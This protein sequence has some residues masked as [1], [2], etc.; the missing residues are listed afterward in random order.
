MTPEEQ[1]AEYGDMLTD[2]EE[3]ILE[4]TI[5][6]SLTVALVSRGDTQFLLEN[7]D[8]LNEILEQFGKRKCSFNFPDEIVFKYLEKKL[9]ENS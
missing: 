4:T 9:N 1:W 2:D 8:K 7:R 6:V 5:L 3:V